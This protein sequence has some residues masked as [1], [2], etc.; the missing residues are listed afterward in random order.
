MPT[1]LVIVATTDLASDQ[2]L[3]RAAS[4]LH[5]DTLQVTLLGRVLPSSGP[6]E[7][8]SYTQIRLHCPLHKGIGFYLLYNLQVL[9]WLIRH[10]P[11]AVTAC[12][13]DTLV[14]ASLGARLVGARL[15]F[16]AHEYFSEVPEVVRRPAI[17][18]VWRTIE[19]IFIPRVD[20]GYTVGPALAAVFSRIYGKPFGTIRNVPLQADYSSNVRLPVPN[21]IVYTGALNEGRGLEQLLQ[22]LALEPAYTAV[23][24]GDGP[25]QAHLQAL[26][27]SLGLQERVRFTGRLLPAELRHQLSQAW[28]GFSLLVPTGESYRLSLANK[29]FDY[30]QAGLPQICP[31]LPEYE[32]VLAQHPVGLALPCTVEAIRGALHRFAAPSFYADAEAAC[33]QAAPFYLWEQEQQKLRALYQPDL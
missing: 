5:G 21:R 12:D 23:I 33:R 28:L 18:A 3:Q 27:A 30:I 15:Y 32:A 22:V 19:H 1:T 26:S 14:G 9:F 20:V 17:Q 31:A 8:H 29:F 11:Q 25:L 13:A 7:V 4:A 24:C 16:D 6:L 2:R 10:R